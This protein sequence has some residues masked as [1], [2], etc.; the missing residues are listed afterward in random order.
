MVVKF[1]TNVEHQFWK[2][3]FPDEKIFAT[4]GDYGY[5]QCAKGCHKKLYDNEQIVSEM[6]SQTK[7]CKIPLELIPKCPVCGGE[8]DV[9]VRKD[10]YFIQDEAWDKACSNYKSFLKEI[11]GKKVVFM[12]LGV[13]FN[14]PGIIRYPFEQMTYSNP[15][16]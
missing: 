1:S 16:K 5:I 10:K 2:A 14:T 15:I 12:E 6:L 4:Q 7:D 9:N 13:G 3:G 11:E 8:M